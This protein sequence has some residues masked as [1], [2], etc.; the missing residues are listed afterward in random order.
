MKDIYGEEWQ[1]WHQRNACSLGQPALLQVVKVKILSDG[2]FMFW[3]LMT[4]PPDWGQSSWRCC[5]TYCCYFSSCSSWWSSWSSCWSSWWWSGRCVDSCCA[6]PLFFFSLCW[7]LS[8]PTS[9]QSRRKRRHRGY[10][11]EHKS[12]GP[13]RWLYI[14][15]AVT[16]CPHLAR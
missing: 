15:A 3:T 11:G 4:F 12:P 9:L 5:A 2:E 13:V 10:Q 14:D 7:H 16:M 1:R 8:S 6:P